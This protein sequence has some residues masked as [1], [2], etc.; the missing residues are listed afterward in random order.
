ML[1][2]DAAKASMS[3][4]LD[5]ST[6]NASVSLG[7]AG[8]IA[9]RLVAACFDWSLEVLPCRPCRRECIAG[10]EFLILVG[11]E[12]AKAPCRYIIM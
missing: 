2:D 5:W 11:E 6:K 12:L 10:S 7:E 1:P 9:L 8:S 4:I 3:K